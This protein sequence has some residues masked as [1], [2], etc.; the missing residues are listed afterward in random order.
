MAFIMHR[1]LAITLAPVIWHGKKHMAV[2]VIEAVNSICINIF[3]MLMEA[4]SFTE[5]AFL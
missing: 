5:P 3:T 2:S 1:S 4:G